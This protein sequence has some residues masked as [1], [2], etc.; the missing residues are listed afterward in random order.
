[1]KQYKGEGTLRLFFAL[2]PPRP[3][4]RAL[5]A[6]AQ[7]AQAVSGGRVTRE[8]SI[9]LTLAFLGDVS[10]DRVAALID[11]ARRVRSTPVELTLDEGRRWEHNGIVWAGPC[12][13]PESLRDLAAQLDAALKTGG[14]KTEKREFKAHI[15]LARRAEKAAAL[16][17]LEPVS[18]RAEEF[19]LV[20]SASSAEGPAYATLSRF[21]LG[22]ERPG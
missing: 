5:H 11:C 21:S 14:F 4:V 1:M 22:S 13:L 8:D 18:W 9:H 3:A 16:P 20:R 6:W 12:A 7:A 19:V 10:G 15:T 2:W 17:Q